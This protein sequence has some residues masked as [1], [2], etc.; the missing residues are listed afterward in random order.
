MEWLRVSWQFDNCLV[1]DSLGK[2][3]GLALLWCNDIYLDICSYSEIHINSVIHDEDKGIDWRITGF[4]GEPVTASRNTSWALL[5]YLASVNNL[6]WLCIGDYKEIL[7]S[8]EKDAW[9]G[10]DEAG[11][12]GLCSKI[13]CCEDKLMTW[14]REVVGHVQSSIKETKARLGSLLSSV[15]SMARKGVNSITRITNE[16][17]IEL[18]DQS[19]IGQEFLHYFTTLFS[20]SNPDEVCS[21]IDV[22]SQSLNDVE[23]R[24]E[25]AIFQGVKDRLSAKT[26]GWQNRQLSPASKLLSLQL[27]L[28]KSEDF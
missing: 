15:D 27:V 25:S 5:R 17:G 11:L 19:A 3:G 26:R 22:I 20:S 23:G 9:E 13:S 6:P 14:N 21:V 16:E 18:I 1:V 7:T 12:R 10:C 4:Y 24:S 8:D 28:D 2:S